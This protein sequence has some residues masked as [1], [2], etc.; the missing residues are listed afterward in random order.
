MIKAIKPLGHKAYGSIPHLPGSRLGPGDWHCHEGQARIATVKTRDKH[1]IVIVQEKLDGSNCSVAKLNGEIIALGRAGYLAESS[2]YPVHHSFYRWVKANEKRFDQLL[3]EG[4]RVAGE[5]LA[6]AV[7]TKYNLSHE[8]FVPFDILI[9]QTR[10]TYETFARRVMK[11]D[12][13][14]PQLLSIGGSFSIEAAM[15]AVERSGHGAIDPVE[16]AI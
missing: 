5:Y 12:F 14:I 9:K 2:E 8:P 6:Q 15:K 4:E 10:I 3:N 1:D 11:F 7:G 16:G 13:T